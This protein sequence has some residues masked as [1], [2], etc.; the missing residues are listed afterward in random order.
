MARHYSPKAFMIEAPNKLLKEYYELEGLNGDI[1]WQHLSERDIG[2]VFEAY[3]NAAEPVRRRMDNDFR[4]IHNLANEGGIKTLIDV[5][6]S[7]FHDTD[8]ISVF[9]G[10]EGHVERAFI[11]FLNHH[12]AFEE[13]S[14]FHYADTLGRW[15]KRKRL[16]RMLKQPDDESKS[17]LSKALSDYYRQKE[18]RGH[19][20]DIEYHKRD[21]RHYWFARPEDYAVSVFIY[22]EQDQF[23]IKTQRPAFEV[24]FVYSESEHSLDIR[25]SGPKETL[26]VLQTLWGRAI[27]ECEVGAPLADSV[28][29]ELG[30]LR[31]RDFQFVLEPE[32]GVLEVRV[33]RLKL[34]IMGSSHRVTLEASARRDPKEVYDLLERVLKGLD[35]SDD[36]LHVASVGL[37]LVFPGKGTRRESTMMFDVSHPNSCSLRDEPKHLIAKNL[38]KRWGLDVSGSAQDDPDEP[39]QPAQRVI[40]RS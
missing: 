4:D 12:E 37:Q 10:A 24:I 11:A 3:E 33:K 23:D 35:V 8:F 18:G 21:N 7:Q 15:R 2:R 40:P 26:L 16:P 9:D 29:Y 34:K 14:C 5:G 36:V 27:L 19:G 17:R 30:A 31:S 39:G 38:L 25:A 20:C 1:P 32:D 6:Q 28:V 22:D 13:A